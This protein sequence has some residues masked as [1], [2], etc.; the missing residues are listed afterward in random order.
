MY[1]NPQLG[2]NLKEKMFPKRI[3]LKMGI[4]HLKMLL[5]IQTAMIK[6]KIKLTLCFLKENKYST[7]LVLVKIGTVQCVFVYD[8]NCSEYT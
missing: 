4:R 3:I 5:E 7:V 6:K 1:I 8:G 2:W